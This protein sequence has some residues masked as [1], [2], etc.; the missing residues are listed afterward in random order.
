MLLK[1]A[2]YSKSTFGFNILQYRYESESLKKTV[3]TWE[4]EKHENFISNIG[5][6]LTVHT[7]RRL[8]KAFHCK[9]KNCNERV[10]AH[11]PIEQTTKPTSLC[12]FDMP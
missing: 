5:G 12:S 3:N 7:W 9:I 11:K 10:S 6:G 4:E 2:S 1:A 8:K